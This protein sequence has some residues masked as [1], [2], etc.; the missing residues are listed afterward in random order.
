MTQLTE[1]KLESIC[2]NI[3]NGNQ[4]D[5]RAQIRGLNKLQLLQLTMRSDQYGLARHIA[6]SQAVIALDR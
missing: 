1:A 2:N 5:A 6:Q 3:I 4:S